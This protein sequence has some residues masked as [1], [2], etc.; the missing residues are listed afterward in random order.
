MSFSVLFLKRFYKS[1][2]SYI[3]SSLHSLAKWNEVD[4]LRLERFS[5]LIAWEKDFQLYTS[6]PRHKVACFVKNQLYAICSATH[7]SIN[8]GEGGDLFCAIT[9]L[10]GQQKATS[11]I[12]FRLAEQHEE[13]HVDFLQKC[14]Q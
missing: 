7:N 6:V 14:K 8:S 1:K 10:V 2:V 13:S 11:Q 3:K 4:V 12:S 9:R 5:A